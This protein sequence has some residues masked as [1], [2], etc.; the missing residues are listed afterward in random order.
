MLVNSPASQQTA[1]QTLTEK[2]TWTSHV[3]KFMWTP[4]AHVI[5]HI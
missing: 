5:L 1:F 4:H 3:Q 2:N